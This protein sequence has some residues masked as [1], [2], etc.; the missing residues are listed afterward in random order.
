MNLKNSIIAT[1]VWTVVVLAVGV[2]MIIYIGTHPVPGA[3]VEQRSQKA[4]SGTGFVAALGYAGIW[5]PFAFKKGQ[6][7]RKMRDKVSAVSKKRP[8]GK[9]MG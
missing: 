3:T 1:V 6:D 4:G 5:L 2:G 7:K 8:G 9:A